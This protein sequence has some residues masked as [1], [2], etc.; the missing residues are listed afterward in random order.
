MNL[1]EIGLF[2]IVWGV[3]KGTCDNY[4]AIMRLGGNN[5]LCPKYI[6]IGYMNLGGCTYS[7]LHFLFIIKKNWKSTRA[8]PILKS[9]STSFWFKKNSLGSEKF[10]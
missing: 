10:S 6:D 1:C 7:T 9:N 8:W 5:V 2:H 4:H 3:S